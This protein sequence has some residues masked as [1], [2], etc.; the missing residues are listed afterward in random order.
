MVD[1]EERANESAAM[2]ANYPGRIPV[3]IPVYF[4]SPELNLAN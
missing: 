4:A 1:A 3:R 2:I